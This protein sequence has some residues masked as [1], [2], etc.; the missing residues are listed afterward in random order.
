MPHEYYAGVYSGSTSTNVVVIDSD[1]VIVASATV[2]TGSDS[3]AAARL[4]LSEAL[5]EAGIIEKE[6]AAIV[7][8]GYGR[9]SVP[10]AARDVTEI[11]CH[12]KGAHRLVPGARTV[13]DIGGQDSKVIRLGPDGSVTEFSMN[14]K[15]AAGTGRFLELM[16]DT[17]G[18]GIDEMARAGL[19]P[20]ETIDISSMCAVFAESEVI[21]LIARGKSTEDIVWGV[22]LAI[23]GRVASMAARLGAVAPY[24]MTGGV[25]N[26]AGV[27]KALGER[28]GER[29]GRH[30]GMTVPDSPQIC[31]ALG[32]AL[33]ARESAPSRI[34][35]PHSSTPAANGGK[36]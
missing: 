14:D 15:C 28:L 35:A 11:T 16:A 21:S 24:A 8:T 2:A 33:I 9:V 20:G 19:H 1:A 17:L 30:D 18:M 31:G 13:I 32:A 12:A 10:F 34:S 23:A 22:D 6:I 25:A 27:V 4:A 7:A 26:N 3:A 5:G 29:S 36:S